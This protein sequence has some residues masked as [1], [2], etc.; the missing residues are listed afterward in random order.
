[1]ADIGNKIA[2]HLFQI[3]LQRHIH[4]QHGNGGIIYPPQTDTKLAPAVIG[5]AG[6]TFDSTVTA[7]DSF[8]IIAEIGGI[9]QFG[10]GSVDK[11]FTE[12]THRCLIDLC[13]PA[14]GIEDQQRI[15]ENLADTR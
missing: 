4:Q 6:N 13:N 8:E 9:D 1:M 5:R 10:D 2:A 15:I 7:K 3:V 11:A 14:I 12:Q